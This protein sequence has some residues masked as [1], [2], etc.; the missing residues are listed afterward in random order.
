MTPAV[1]VGGGG[2]TR[3]RAFGAPSMVF[4]KPNVV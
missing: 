1:A 4:N 2:V 3:T